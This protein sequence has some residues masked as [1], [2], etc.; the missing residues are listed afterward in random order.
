MKRIDILNKENSANVFLYY[1]LANKINVDIEQILEDL[2][3]FK[4][5]SQESDKAMIQTSR[6]QLI[7]IQAKM[8]KLRTRFHKSNSW[9]MRK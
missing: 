4:G 3:K 9:F 8:D 7:K 6:N 2:K 1:D 5:L